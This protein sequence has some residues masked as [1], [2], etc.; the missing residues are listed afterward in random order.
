MSVDIFKFAVISSYKLLSL[1][2]KYMMLFI[3]AT[4]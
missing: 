3:H 4:F 1:L 2:S